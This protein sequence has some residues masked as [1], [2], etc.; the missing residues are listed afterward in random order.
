M[1]ELTEEEENILLKKARRMFDRSITA[2][3]VVG[4]IK[5]HPEL[6]DIDLTKVWKE[7]YLGIKVQKEEKW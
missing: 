1:N 2:T 7:A 3:V 4:Y 5:L 6:K